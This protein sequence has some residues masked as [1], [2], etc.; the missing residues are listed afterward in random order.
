MVAKALSTN[1]A[2]SEMFIASQFHRIIELRRSDM[3]VQQATLSCHRGTIFFVIKHGACIEKDSSR[4]TCY[5]EDGLLPKAKKAKQFS[6]LILWNFG[7]LG[8]GIWAKNC[9][10]ELYSSGLQGFAEG[11]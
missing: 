2:R 3:L 1:S 8:R 4:M 11:F 10:D 7:F 5:L 6:I 9:T